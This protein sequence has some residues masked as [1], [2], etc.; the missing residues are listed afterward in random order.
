M[1]LFSTLDLLD[2]RMPYIYIYIYIYILYVAVCISPITIC[3]YNMCV[4]SSVYWSNIALLI[5]IQEE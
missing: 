3:V 4:C 2:R 5:K 1:E